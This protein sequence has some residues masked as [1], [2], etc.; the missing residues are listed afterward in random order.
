M[1]SAPLP[2]PVTEQEK[3]SFN[4]RLSRQS[5]A[6]ILE[7][8]ESAAVG[9]DRE[10]LL[11]EEATPSASLKPS[12]SDK[13]VSCRPSP[14]TNDYVGY[15]PHIQL[16]AAVARGV[17]YNELR[18]VA[19]KATRSL[20]S[21]EKPSPTGTVRKISPASQDLATVN[22]SYAVEQADKPV[23]PNPLRPNSEHQR[24]PGAN[25]GVPGNRRTDLRKKFLDGQEVMTTDVGLNPLTSVPRGVETANLTEGHPSK[26]LAQASTARVEEQI[27]ITNNSQNKMP[28][29]QRMVP[30]WGTFLLRQQRPRGPHHAPKTPANNPSKQPV[31][32]QCSRPQEGSREVIDLTASNNEPTVPNNCPVRTAPRKQNVTSEGTLRLSGLPLQPAAST[33]VSSSHGQVPYISQGPQTLPPST[34]HNNA[35]PAAALSNADRP[36]PVALCPLHPNLARMSA[37]EVYRSYT[38]IIL[39]ADL[40]LFHRMNLDDHDSLRQRATEAF[41]AGNATEYHRLLSQLLQAEHRCEEILEHDRRARVTPG[42]L[43]A[44]ADEIRRIDDEIRRFHEEG[45]CTVEGHPRGH[46]SRWPL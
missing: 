39:T 36:I 29:A 7:V 33:P 17:F 28:V 11:A 44:H 18:R 46:R 20:N 34:Q 15:A 31:P 8:E 42:Y 24:N 4:R 1:T 16:M 38:R 45:H 2:E 5:D 26:S 35:P 25:S 3:P 27:N 23:T 43:L 10:Y 32:F 40:A 37:H 30:A 6:G 19:P 41:N 13:A 14:P 22:T 9:P 21:M 12:A